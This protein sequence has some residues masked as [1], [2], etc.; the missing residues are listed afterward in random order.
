MGMG[1]GVLLYQPFTVAEIDEPPDPFFHL[2]L[3]NGRLCP[4]VPNE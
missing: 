4:S 1:P 3:D 2:V